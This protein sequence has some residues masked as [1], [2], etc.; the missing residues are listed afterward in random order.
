MLRTKE[1]LQNHMGSS[2]VSGKA[3][4]GL[5]IAKKASRKTLSCTPS[6]REVCTKCERPGVWISESKIEDIENTKFV[7]EFVISLF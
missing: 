7:R 3:L 2:M 4:I 6:R 1:E 5:D